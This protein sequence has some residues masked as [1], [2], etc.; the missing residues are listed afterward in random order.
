MNVC[1]L[2]CKD[3]LKSCWCGL[4][5]SAE[6]K[7]GLVGVLVR[8]SPTFAFSGNVP[9]TTFRQTAKVAQAQLAFARKFY[10]KK[11]AFA[12]A[13]CEGLINL[14]AKIALWVWSFNKFEGLINLAAKRV[15]WVWSL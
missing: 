13:L 11:G 15:L 2:A 7:N 10:H 4:R 1:C 8:H 6:Y 12:C 3:A 5:A 14:T 9:G